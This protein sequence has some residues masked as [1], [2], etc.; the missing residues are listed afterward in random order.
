MEITKKI[1]LGPLPAC[2]RPNCDSADKISRLDDTG[3]FGVDSGFDFEFTRGRPATQ[4]VRA[5]SATFDPSRGTAIVTAL[6]KNGDTGTLKIPNVTFDDI[7]GQQKAK[8][9]LIRLA[10]VLKNPALYAKRGIGIPRGVVLWGPPGNG[11]TLLAKALANHCETYFYLTSSSALTSMWYGEQ[12][13]NI[14]KLF[15]EARETGG[16]IFFDEAED[17]AQSRANPNAHQANKKAVTALN[18]NMD[19]FET[20]DRV[21]VMFATNRLEGLDEAVIRP[22][23]IDY[24]VEVPNP[25]T[26][27]RKEI[28][29]ICMRSVE[30][31]ARAP[32]FVRPVDETKVA[33]LTDGLS[34][35]DIT[36]VVKNA[37][38][39]KVW[40]EY[41]GEKPTLVSIDDIVRHVE[42]FRTERGKNASENAGENINTG[43]YL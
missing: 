22:G 29:Q 32:Q 3:R 41:D 25:D 30:Q 15:Q 12:E 23:R 9:K 33:E 5:A 4:A 20:N 35:A 7:G 16:I 19:G 21:V 11:K 24:L 37:I 10:T 2:K 1:F 36:R 26:A 42:L 27:G 14:D 31:K 13:Q 40:S 8:E 17:I 38:E 34:G 28:L 18:R 43:Q 6:R 39:E